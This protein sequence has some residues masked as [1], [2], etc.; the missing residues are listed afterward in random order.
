M[1]QA[2]TLDSDSIHDSTQS[3][4]PVWRLG[5]TDAPHS[6]LFRASLSLS[7]AAAARFVRRARAA[8]RPAAV[9]DMIKASGASPPPTE[10]ARRPTGRAGMVI[11]PAPA[12]LTPQRRLWVR[13]G[14]GIGDLWVRS[15]CDVATLSAT[16]GG[17]WT[18]G[19][20][21]VV[22]GTACSEVTAVTADAETRDTPL[23]CTA[24]PAAA[25]LQCCA[26]ETRQ[27]SAKQRSVE[28]RQQRDG[29][30]NR[31]NFTDL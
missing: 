30:S 15:V 13:S 28:T 5:L 7:P 6:R 17:I 24:Q 4:L 11:R 26:V 12:P 10:K 23:R 18:S 3:R 27:Q 9:T 25:A 21:E 22:L 14:S 29:K 31:R 2:K 20:D 16:G 19:R 1:I 8:S